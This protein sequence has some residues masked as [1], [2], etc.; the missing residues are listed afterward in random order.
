MKRASAT[1]TMPAWLVFTIAGVLGLFYAYVV[2][3]AVTLLVIQATGPLGLS[4]LGWGVLLFAVAFPILAY[5]GA[6]ALGWRRRAGEFA[7]IL[8]TGLALVA[9]FWLSIL[10]YAYSAGTQL[11]GSS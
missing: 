2:W 6:F 8:V 5:A 10:A 1:R 3:N 7:L 11:L 9:C 4:G